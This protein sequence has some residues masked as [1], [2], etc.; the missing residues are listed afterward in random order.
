MGPYCICHIAEPLTIR[1][2]PWYLTKYK[3]QKQ[4]VF[5]SS[6]SL[7]SRNTKRLPHIFLG[8]GLAL[9]ARSQGLCCPWEPQCPCSPPRSVL[10]VL[11]ISCPMAAEA[12]SQT[13]QHTTIRA[14]NNYSLVVLE[15]RSPRSRCGKGHAPSRGS[16][17]GSLLA[18]SSFWGPQVP[19]ACSPI[20]PVFAS[21]SM[22]SSPLNFSMISSSVFWD[23]CPWV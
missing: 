1:G 23:T 8:P 15:A 9:Q 6:S 7:G 10:P 16:R 11:S 19:L 21:V 13:S 20:T 12:V 17:Q 4:T 2:S 22:W 5:R 3:T 14:Q 18:S